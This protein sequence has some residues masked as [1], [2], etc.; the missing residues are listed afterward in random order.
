MEQAYRKN[1]GGGICRIIM[2]MQLKRTEDK[3]KKVHNHRWSAGEGRNVIQG[4]IG[5]ITETGR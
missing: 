4:M 3:G 2:E 5:R 1:R